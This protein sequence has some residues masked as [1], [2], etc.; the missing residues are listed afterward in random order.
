MAG[1]PNAPG[2]PDEVPGAPHVSRYIEREY[3][4]EEALLGELVNDL[5]LIVS[6][7]GELIEDAGSKLTKP[8]YRAHVLVVMQPR[9]AKA[10]DVLMDIVNR[11]RALPEAAALS[12]AA[13][14]VEQPK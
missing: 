11:C 7:L 14:P 8:Q 6:T 13:K 12:E 5:D 2:T 10:H 4:N 1:T 3:S 9:M